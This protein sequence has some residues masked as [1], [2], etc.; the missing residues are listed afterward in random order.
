MPCCNRVPRAK[1]AKGDMTMRCLLVLRASILT[2]FVVILGAI[3]GLSQETQPD[4]R[5]A[6]V[7][8]KIPE[9]AKLSVDGQATTQTGTLRR[10]TSPPLEAGKSYGYTLVAVIEPNNYTTITRTRKITVLAGK[11]TEVDMTTK[12]AKQ[13]DNIVIRW[14]PTPEPVV[15][16]MLKLARVGKDDVVYDLGCG[17]GRIVVTAVKDFGAKR[18]VGFDIDPERIKESKAR[19]KMEKVED[20]AEFRQENVLK[21]KDFSPATVVTLYMSD[22]L[23]EAVRPDLVK[24]LKPGSRIVSHRF[25]MGDWKPEQTKVIPFE[26]DEYQVHLWTVGKK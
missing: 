10:F 21:I 22:D 14:V 11:A 9:G 20:K 15:E 17:D 23:N 1:D 8:V 6:T 24:T 18:G 7:V 2:S 25:L 4:A 19:A 16:A 13:P 3:P 12:D 5:R 26:G